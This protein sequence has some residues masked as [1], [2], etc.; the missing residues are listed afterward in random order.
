MTPPSELEGCVLGHLWK[1][2]PCTAYSVRRALFDSPSLHW[3]GSA[4]AVY[5]LL[6]RLEERG[7]VRSKKTMR[8]D[9]VGWPCSITPAG[10]ARLL[11]WLGPPIAPDVVAITPDPLRTRLYFLS[12]LD[13]RRRA[14]FFTQA[15]AALE[16]HLAV[17]AAEET[18][19]EFDRLALRG[20]LALTRA[21]IAWLEQVRRALSPR[22]RTKAAARR[23]A[24]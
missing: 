20:A 4:G 15:R 1:H 24:E 11:A 8:G 17:L 13:S 21:R 16:E 6:A 22:E 9:R 23:I 10:R 7:F 5:P 14:T 12:A 3:S 18:P 19:D 2:G